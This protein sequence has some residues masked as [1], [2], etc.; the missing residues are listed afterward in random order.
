MGRKLTRSCP[1]SR[2]ATDV[3]LG[4]GFLWAGIE[5][6]LNFAGDAAPWSA[7]GFLKFA[8]AGTV[9]NMVGHADT[10]VHNPTQGIWLGLA[11]SPG[12]CSASSTSWSSSARSQSA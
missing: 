2:D 5:K 6:W 11:A 4:V 8:T 10:M 9:P 7:A 3:V 1:G 12:V